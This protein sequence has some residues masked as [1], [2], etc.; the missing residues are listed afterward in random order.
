VTG[1]ASR[2][3]MLAG[4]QQ[5][6]ASVRPGTPTRI[7]TA[8]VLREH[9][10]VSTAP[11]ATWQDLQQWVEVLEGWFATPWVPA[12]AG[13]RRCPMREPCQGYC[14]LLVVSGSMGACA[15]HCRPGN[16]GQRLPVLLTPAVIV[17]ER[18]LQLPAKEAAKEF[19]MCLSTLKKFCRKHGVLRWPSRK[20]KMLDRK[21]ES[22]GSSSSSSSLE[23]R[24]ELRRKLQALERERAILP[25]AVFDARDSAPSSP[26]S[27]ASTAVAGDCFP[28]EHSASVSGARSPSSSSQSP[29]IDSTTAQP[30]IAAGRNSDG[31]AGTE[32]TGRRQAPQADGKVKLKR[33]GRASAASTTPQLASSADDIALIQ[34]LAGCASTSS[35]A[36]SGPQDEVL[37]GDMLLAAALAADASVAQGEQNVA[38]YEGPIADD[39]RLAAELARCAEE[40][41]A[42]PEIPEVGATDSDPFWGDFSDD[43]EGDMIG[44]FDV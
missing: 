39:G 10:H 22:L 20:L 6:A 32:A 25:I 40:G 5:G 12:H 37:D 34:A 27:T 4:A 42:E 33:K 3:D 19:G 31:G 8:E 9:L 38:W 21:I 11:G 43:A 24:E 2:R 23:D 44:I 14:P 26:A 16:S 30:W 7:V 28:S 1:R 13:G 36:A 29:I 15:W 35:G 41:D 17:T 18:L